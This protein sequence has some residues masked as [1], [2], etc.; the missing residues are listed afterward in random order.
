MHA[1]LRHFR[2]FP[3]NRKEYYDTCLYYVNSCSATFSHVIRHPCEIARNIQSP[4]FREPYVW[5]C[6]YHH[7]CFFS[8]PRC[9]LIL[10]SIHSFSS[11]NQSSC[12]KIVILS[13]HMR[14]MSWYV[15]EKHEKV[16]VKY[17]WGSRDMTTATRT[18]HFLF[19]EISKIPPMASVFIVRT[20]KFCQHARRQSQLASSGHCQ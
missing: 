19:H 16:V 5:R 3:W 12:F 8:A 2:H 17:N 11:T 6:S 4:P 10:I 20:R 9:V 1:P 13:L 15:L 14:M 18:P 7:D